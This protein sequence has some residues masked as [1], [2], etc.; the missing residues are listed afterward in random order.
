MPDILYPNVCRC[1]EEEPLYWDKKEA[2][3]VC[4]ERQADKKDWEGLRDSNNQSLVKTELIII[5]KLAYQAL[6]LERI[7]DRCQKEPQWPQQLQT[8][9]EQKVYD[10]DECPERQYTD[11][12]KPCR[13][14]SK[15]LMALNNKGK[16][17]IVD[18][19]LEQHLNIVVYQWYVSSLW[20]FCLFIAANSSNNNGNPD[21]E[22][23]EAIIET[24]V[25]SLKEC[26]LHNSVQLI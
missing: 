2:E 12:N 17:E 14:T 21:L 6:V 7:I 16:C 15:V 9:L 13:I 4:C 22:L 1:Q 25:T 19:S 8:E 20:L 23:F 10:Q 3:E 11:V 5:G 24:W 18:H 26:H